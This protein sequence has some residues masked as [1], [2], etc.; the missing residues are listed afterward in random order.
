MTAPY[1]AAVGGPPLVL[2]HGEK[3]PDGFLRVGE[4]GSP[5]LVNIISI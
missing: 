5:A 3:A 2:L 4:L 1:F